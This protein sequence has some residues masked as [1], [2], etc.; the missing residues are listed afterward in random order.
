VLDWNVHRYGGT[1]QI[2]GEIYK[3]KQ[4]NLVVIVIYG[5]FRKRFI[6]VEVVYL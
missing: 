6:S 5:V 2:L 1:E 3:K 4:E